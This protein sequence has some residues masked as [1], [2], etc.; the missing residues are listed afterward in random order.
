[1]RTL[2]MIG[3]G[4]AAMTGVLLAGWLLGRAGIALNAPVLFIV[5]WAAWC[6][7]DSYV[8]TT[9][10]YGWGTELA[11]HTPIFLVPAVAAWW[12]GRRFALT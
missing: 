10:G 7:W 1:M 6:L 5:C 4:L 8:G 3:T 12:L 11:I 2:M 9:H